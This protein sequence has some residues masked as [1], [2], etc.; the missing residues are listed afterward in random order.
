M[1]KMM[2]FRNRQQVRMCIFTNIFI[3]YYAFKIFISNQQAYD[4]AAKILN[5]NKKTKVGLTSCTWKNKLG[6]TLNLVQ[7]Q[8]KIEET[9]LDKSKWN[10]SALLDI[11]FFNKFQKISMN[12]VHHW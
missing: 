7:K 9:P 2:E 8:K 10:Q 1:R 5:E 6:P 11:L 4:N 3:I 12:L